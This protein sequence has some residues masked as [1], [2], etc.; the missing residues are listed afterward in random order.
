MENAAMQSN[1]WGEN[2]TMLFH[3]IYMIH[4]ILQASLM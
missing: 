3:V 4:L 2:Y 1:S